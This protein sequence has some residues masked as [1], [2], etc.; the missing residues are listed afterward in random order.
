ME[1]ENNFQI[2]YGEKLYLD[3]VELKCV[4][5]YEVSHSAGEPLA[6]LTLTM[7]VTVNQAVAES[8][9]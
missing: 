7:M 6:E 5:K 2:G 8:E 9:K 3:D 4:T 1:A